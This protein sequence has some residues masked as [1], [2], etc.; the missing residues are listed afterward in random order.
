MA[1]WSQEQNMLLDQWNYV[2]PCNYFDPYD[3]WDDDWN[4]DWDD[5]WDDY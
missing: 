5:D 4:D 3:D 2:P 1:P